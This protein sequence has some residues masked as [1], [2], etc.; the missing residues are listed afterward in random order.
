MNDLN[1]IDAGQGEAMSA[2]A[3]IDAS[4]ESIAPAAAAPA[5]VPDQL[6]E[7]KIGGQTRRVPLNELLQGYSR[8]QDYTQKTMALAE[9]RRQLEARWNGERSQIREFLTKPENVQQLYNHLVQQQQTS[10]PANPQP[11]TMQ[12]IQALQQQ[13][14]SRLAQERQDIE[15]KQIE[16]TYKTDIQ[17]HIAQIL[18][19]NPELKSIRKIDVILR[20]AALEQDPATVEEAK[21]HILTA[22]QEQVAAIRNHFTTA[23]KSAALNKQTLTRGIEPPGGAAPMPAAKG[24]IKFGSP[25]FNADV[26]AYFRQLTDAAK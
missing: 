1:P 26:A 7:V 17:G 12:H 2:D 22:A 13:I 14:E 20:Q 16:S 8:T 19:Q 11:V 18:E 4:P 21:Q 6:Y 25:E 9:E 5:A 24:P 23:Q 3:P 10:N 15:L